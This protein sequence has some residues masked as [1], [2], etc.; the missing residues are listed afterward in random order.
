MKKDTVSRVPFSH[1]P[2]YRATRMTYLSLLGSSYFKFYTGPRPGDP[3]R[4]GLNPVYPD[5]HRDLEP[6]Q[7]RGTRCRSIT[8]LHDTRDGVYIP[9][10]VFQKPVDVC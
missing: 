7:G 4:Q 1:S 6:A 2:H 9:C 10:K 8:T 3:T 5:P